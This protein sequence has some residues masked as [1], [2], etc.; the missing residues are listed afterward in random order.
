DSRT[1]SLLCNPSQSLCDGV[2][3]IVMATVRERE[4]LSYQI[5]RPRCG[6]W[7][8]D[9]AILELCLDGAESRH[10]V[11]VGP[12]RNDWNLLTF[13]VLNKTRARS[14]VLYEHMASRSP[15]L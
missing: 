9:R 5:V 10:F 4:Q 7:E 3:L 6:L 1:A 11:R 15:I 13:Q 12:H 8:V 14:F 2:D